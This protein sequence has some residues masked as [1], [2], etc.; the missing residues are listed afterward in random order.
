MMR[1]LLV[2]C[3]LLL[4]ADT[5][6]AQYRSPPAGGEALYRWCSSRVYYQH[7]PPR[8]IETSNVRGG[9]SLKQFIEVVDACVRSHGQIY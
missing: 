7:Q 2:C 8:R 9:L 1:R 3:A 5:A 4:L 6:E